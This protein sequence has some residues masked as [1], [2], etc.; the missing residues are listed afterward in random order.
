[1]WDHLKIRV[2]YQ[3]NNTAKKEFETFDEA[4]EYADAYIKQYKKPCDF[5]QIVRFYTDEE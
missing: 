4:R 5:V 2:L 3:T 1:M